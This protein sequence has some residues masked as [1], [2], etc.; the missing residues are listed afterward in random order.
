MKH[1]KIATALY[2]PLMMMMIGPTDFGHG[3]HF[4]P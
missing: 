2:H 4:D 1:P 3:D